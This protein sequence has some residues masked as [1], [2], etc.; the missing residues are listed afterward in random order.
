MKNHTFYSFSIRFVTV[1]RSRLP[2]FITGIDYPPSRNPKKQKY[3]FSTLNRILSMKY[4]QRTLYDIRDMIRTSGGFT[5][6]TPPSKGFLLQKGG[7]CSILKIF[8]RRGGYSQKIFPSEFP[9]FQKPIYLFFFFL[10]YPSFQ[11]VKIKIINKNI[12]L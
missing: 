12:Q 6:N 1:S 3:G 8:F 10:G 2:R 4:C 9:Q 5:V 7:I 11:S